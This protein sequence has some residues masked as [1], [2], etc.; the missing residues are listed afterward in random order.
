MLGQPALLPVHLRISANVGIRVMPLAAQLVV[1][2]SSE[3]VSLSS[4]RA[5]L[6]LLDRRLQLGQFLNCLEASAL[7]ECDSSRCLRA[8]VGRFRLVDPGVDRP[9]S[10]S[11]FK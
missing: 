8:A 10:D 4:L 2:E 3:P 6:E 11:S 9:A 7:L 5:I 1:R